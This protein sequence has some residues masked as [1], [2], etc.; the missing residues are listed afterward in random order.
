MHKFW[1]NL[2]YVKGATIGREGSVGL[3]VEALAKGTALAFTFPHQIAEVCFDAGGSA[4]LGTCPLDANPL[5]AFFLHHKQ[6]QVALF[7]AKLQLTVG[8]QG[9]GNDG[10][11]HNGQPKKKEEQVENAA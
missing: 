3:R 8:C 11:G 5:V 10:K 9:E 2:I 6:A 1:G 7:A 4:A